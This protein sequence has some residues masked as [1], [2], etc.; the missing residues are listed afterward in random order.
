MQLV[1]CAVQIAYN[2]RMDDDESISAEEKERQEKCLGKLTWPTLEAAQAAATYAQWQYGGEAK[3]APYRCK[4]C[5][6]WHLA[7]AQSWNY[8]S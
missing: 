8:L 3:P 7:R 2:Q 5:N 1:F 6:R 4:F